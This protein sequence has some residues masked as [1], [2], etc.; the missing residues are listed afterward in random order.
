MP[1]CPVLLSPYHRRVWW[2]VPCRG[3]V[4]LGVELFT[5]GAWRICLVTKME[6]ARIEAVPWT[7]RDT[8]TVD[9]QGQGLVFPVA[10]YASSF[11]LYYLGV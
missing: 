7:I 2:T 9:I 3:L 10:A 11:F 1:F 5:L 4:Y 8:R 6:E